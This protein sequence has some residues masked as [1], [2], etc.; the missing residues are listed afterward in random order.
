MNL[1]TAIQHKDLEQLEACISQGA[2]VNQ[3]ERSVPYALTCVGSA[4]YRGAY[5]PLVKACQIGFVQGAIVLIQ[6]GA[7][8]NLKDCEG[9]TPLHHA[10]CFDC[11][12]MVRLLCDHGANIH[13]TMGEVRLRRTPLQYALGGCISDTRFEIAKELIARGS[14]VYAK[15]MRG[16]IPFHACAQS[17]HLESVKYFL[18]LHPR[19]VHIPN[20]KGKVAIHMARTLEILL[21][22]LRAGAQVSTKDPHQHTALHRAC[23][24][25]N[26][27]LQM[28]RILIEYG[29]DIHAVD[30]FGETPLSYAWDI[31]G[32]DVRGGFYNGHRHPT[33][34][35]VRFL[36]QNGANP[37]IGSYS[38]YRVHLKLGELEDIRKRYKVQVVIFTLV[39]C[40]RVHRFGIESR[41]KLLPVDIIRRLVSFLR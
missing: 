40:I 1:F 38:E 10:V 28:V 22:C 20:H 25:E 8:V 13:T 31:G 26:L 18:E 15:D 3:A 14:D 17:T 9:M 12:E 24:Y 11:P 34:E 27:P 32:N 21:A 23:R 2:D 7:N 37:H 30:T 29:A 41:V 6:H 5:T 36:L 4:F 33:S 19:M 35:K 39:S 16:N